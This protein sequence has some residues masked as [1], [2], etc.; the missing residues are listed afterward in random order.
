MFLRMMGVGLAG[1]AVVTATA[2]VAGA[3]VAGVAVLACAARRRAKADSAWP[4]EA[5]AT[6]TPAEEN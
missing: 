2:A 1:I 4:R 5:A 3:A 6:P